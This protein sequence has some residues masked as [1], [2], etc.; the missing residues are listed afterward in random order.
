LVPKRR[1]HRDSEVEVSWGDRLSIIKVLPLPLRAGFSSSVSLESRKGTWLFF[2]PRA[3]NTPVKADREV[4][5]FLDSLSACPCNPLLSAL[6][7]PARS[8]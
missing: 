8:T 6:S 3:K 1:L 5:M 4:L 2:L 7:E